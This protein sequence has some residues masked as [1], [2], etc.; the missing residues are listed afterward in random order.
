[1]KTIYYEQCPICL[2]QYDRRNLKTGVCD[3]CQWLID[4][5]DPKTLD[6]YFAIPLSQITGILTENEL[7][8]LDKR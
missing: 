8:R 5:G 6:K 7:R 1:M 2:K 3:H 4:S